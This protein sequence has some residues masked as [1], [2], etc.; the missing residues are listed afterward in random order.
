METALTIRNVL[1]RSFVLTYL[2]L[3]LTWFL[4][5]HEVYYKT[6][7]FFYHMNY[8]ETM[9]FTLYVISFIKIFG[10]LC[11]LIPA[12]AIHWEYMV[13]KAKKK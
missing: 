4:S 7:K 8:V 13:H 5:R 9:Q 6:I 10:I 1:L 3:F 11:L 12:I 2:I